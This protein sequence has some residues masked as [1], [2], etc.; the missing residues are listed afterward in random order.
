MA[1]KEFQ[2]ENRFLS[3]FWDAKVVLDGVTYPTVEHAYQ[4]A[5]TLDKERR[6]VIQAQPTPGKA[7]RAGQRVKIRSDWENVKVG[8]M[9]DLVRQKFKNNVK[10]KNRLLATGSEELIEGNTWGDTFWGRCRG[11][12]KNHL[13]KILM[14]VRSELDG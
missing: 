4:A 14:K 12:G 10:L 7:K 13:G 3:N 6:K 1:I 5:K 9:L 2:G 11:V 8:I